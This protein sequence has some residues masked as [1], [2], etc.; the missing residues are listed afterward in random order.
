MVNK[1]LYHFDSICY[2]MNVFTLY[3]QFHRLYMQAICDTM[4]KGENYE[5]YRYRQTGG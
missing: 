2:Y 4:L 3:V 1:K 5:V